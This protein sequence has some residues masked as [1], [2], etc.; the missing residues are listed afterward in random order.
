MSRSARFI[1]SPS[2]L[3]PVLGLLLL[4]VGAAT[5][6][7]PA[8]V[9]VDAAQRFLSGLTA[10]QRGAARVSL[11][12]PE[13]TNWTYVPRDRGG[14]P[15]RAMDRE[16]R[17]AAF[18]LLGHG[19]S[20]RGVALARGVIALE[21]SL[22]ELEAAAGSPWAARRDP[23]LY[24]FWL[25]GEPDALGPW[26]WRFEGHHLSINVSHAGPGTIVAPLFVGANPARVPSGPQAGLRLLAAEED[27]AFELL[28]MLD[29]EQRARATV[30]DRTSG[31]ILTRDDP[32]VRAMAFDGLSASAMS[33]AQQQALRA[34]LELY[35]GRM[36]DTAARAQ[37]ARIDEAGFERLY[38]AWAGAHRPGQPH[39]YR[40]HGPTVLIEYDNSQN[41]ANHIHTVWRDLEN[42][43]GGDMLR[44]HYARQ[45]HRH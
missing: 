30:G 21:G 41:H 37:L 22:R 27:L 33:A 11:D 8:V 3:L 29:A 7:E 42:D 25:F 39:Y 1:R 36:A 44:A 13:R 24:H 31:D 2:P 4:G 34:L 43:F 20:E 17:D 16:Q 9:A 35:A 15:L 10:E 23:G 26:A 32:A 28:G 19:L 45:A 14:V 6:G 38:F 18:G 12:D 5:A 40:I